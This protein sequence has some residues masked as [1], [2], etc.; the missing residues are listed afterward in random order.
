MLGNMV[1]RFLL[2]VLA[3]VPS[4]LSCSA[5]A[6]PVRLAFGLTPEAMG[7]GRGAVY[8]GGG[9]LVASAN[10]QI[11]GGIGGEVNATVGLADALDLELGLA[12]S[13]YAGASGMLGGGVRWQVLRGATPVLFSAGI[14]PGVG[15]NRE[16]PAPALGAYAGL[17]FGFR[18]T[19]ET[20]IYLGNRV[21]ATA[22][23]NNCSVPQN[24]PERFFLHSAYYGHH[25]LGLQHD[26]NPHVFTSAE[27]GVGYIWGSWAP[28]FG[29]F[30]LEWLGGL[31]FFA[32]VGYR[33][34]G[35]R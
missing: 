28:E 8:G 34:G 20:A 15:D 31:T 35:P 3:G 5:V 14:G 6:P 4:S 23:I 16:C 11:G 1:G 9:V 32:S 30:N 27:V 2:V 25:V 18:M 17:D 13:L 22:S 10:N 24:P 33:W 7:P 26:W 19:S 21:S 29:S 12:G